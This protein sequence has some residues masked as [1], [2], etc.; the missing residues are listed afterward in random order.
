A[1]VPVSWTDW[2]R[3][4][5]TLLAEAD[6]AP[7]LP[8]DRLAGSSVTYATVLQFGRVV[9]VRENWET[10]RRRLEGVR[11][12]SA[13]LGLPGPLPGRSPLDIPAG[14]QADQAAGRLQELQRLYPR[15]Q[16]EFNLAELPETIVG[17]IRQTARPRYEN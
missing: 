11:D 15:F 2:H 14:F 10:V 7:H 4:V 13:A 17:E 3:E 6:A 9:A 16:Q 1:G 8:A 5:Q 12:L